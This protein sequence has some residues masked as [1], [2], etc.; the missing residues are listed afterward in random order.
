MFSPN[1]QRGVT[2]IEI[3][4]VVIIIGILAM[5]VL[6]RF[7]GR[8]EEARVSVTKVAVYS[9]IPVALD[10]Y[11]L[12]NGS[13]PSTEQSL[14]ALFEK[15]ESPPIPAN[16]K[17][18][19]LKKKDVID[20]WGNPFLYRYPGEHNTDSYDLYSSGPDGQEGT[21]DDITNWEEEED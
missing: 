9:S 21:E 18:P 19:Y 5:M 1:D 2:L 8:S 20:V 10:L 16:W 3:M 4:L 11:E 7:A 15:P 17:K 14:Q 12:D 13:Y 6:P